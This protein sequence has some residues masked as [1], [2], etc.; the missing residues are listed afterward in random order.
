MTSQ[1]AEIIKAVKIK[2]NGRPELETRA[3]PESDVTADDI[4]AGALNSTNGTPL[5]AFIQEHFE[6]I[7]QALLIN[8]SLSQRKWRSKT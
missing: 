5:H 3:S 6:W 7:D 1:L 4:Q 2:D 8:I